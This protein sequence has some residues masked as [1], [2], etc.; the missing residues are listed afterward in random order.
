MAFRP[1]RVAVA[2]ALLAV[3]LL[4]VG[5]AQGSG[6]HAHAEQTP[7]L[8]VLGASESRGPAPL[9][10]AGDPALATTTVPDAYGG[11]LADVETSIEQGPAEPADGEAEHHHAGAGA[12]VAEAAA[13]GDAPPAGQGAAVSEADALVAATLARISFPWQDALTGWDVRFLPGR[14]GVRGLTFPA[15]QR[16]EIY[17]RNSDTPAT[18]AR[19]LAHELGHALDVERNDARDRARWRQVRGVGPTVPWWPDDAATDFA[20]MAGDFAEAFAVWQTGV[21]SQSSVAGQPT[22]E[23]LAVLVELVS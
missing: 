23:Q 6:L 3:S 21:E 2:S 15:T 14:S 10:A 4:G 5:C 8:Q 13:R 22:P 17:V 18:L 12:D 16:I 19:V 1:K 9:A 7:N 20:T 11:V